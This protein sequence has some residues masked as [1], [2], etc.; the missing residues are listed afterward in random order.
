M[1]NLRA[2]DG[3][4]SEWRI[5]GVGGA[6]D[7]KGKGRSKLSHKLQ[8]FQESDYMDPDQDLCL[9]ALFNIAATNCKVLTLEED[10]ASL[11]FAGPLKC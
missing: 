4:V 7:E 3:T 11:A 1:V 9:D 5:S 2:V 6:H 8:H 10:Y